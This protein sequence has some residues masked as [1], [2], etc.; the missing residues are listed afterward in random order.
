MADFMRFG[1]MPVD[2]WSLPNDTAVELRRVYGIIE[3]V[4]REARDRE[5]QAAKRG[6]R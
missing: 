6:R 2:L 5:D 1:V 4:K 3:Q